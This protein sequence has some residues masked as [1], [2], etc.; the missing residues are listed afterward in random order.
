MSQ[1][2]VARFAGVRSQAAGVVTAAVTLLTMLL[3]APFIARL[4][5]A[6]LAA[7]VIVYSVGLIKPKEF[8]AI[9]TVRRTEFTWALVALAWRAGHT[10]E[11]LTAR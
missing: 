6:T 2:A 3:L 5:E 9:L 10:G 7:V 4:P 1:T 8:R 11:R